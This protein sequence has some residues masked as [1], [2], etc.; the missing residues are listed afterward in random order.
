MN[1]TMNKYEPVTVGEWLWREVDRM[2]KGQ[3]Q[4]PTQA[5]HH[6][7]H[8][9]FDYYNDYIAIMNIYIYITWA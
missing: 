8:G 5:P 7:V 6:I 4:N 2:D 3:W 1:T 9:I